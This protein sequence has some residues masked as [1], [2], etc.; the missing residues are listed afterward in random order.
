MTTLYQIKLRGHL[1][2]RHDDWLEGFSMTLQP[3]GET[4]LTGWVEDQA[5]LFGVLLR[6]RDLGIPLLSLNA[7]DPESAKAESDLK[8]E[9]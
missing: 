8:P 3:N 9:A 7:I 2:R 4:I 6:I 5:A 1:D